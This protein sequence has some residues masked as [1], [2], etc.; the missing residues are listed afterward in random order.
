MVI[1]NRAWIGWSPSM[2]GVF[3]GPIH[4]AFSLS[5][6]CDSRI[7][8]HYFHPFSQWTTV[9]IRTNASGLCHFIVNIWCFWAL[10]ETTGGVSFFFPPGEQFSLEPQFDRDDAIS[11]ASLSLYIIFISEAHCFDDKENPHWYLSHLAFFIAVSFHIKSLLSKIELQSPGEQML[12]WRHVITVPYQ[13][14]T[15]ACVPRPVTTL[16]LS[17]PGPFGS[18]ML[19]HHGIVD[20]NSEKLEVSRDEAPLKYLSLSIC[21]KPFYSSIIQIDHIHCKSM[22]KEGLNPVISTAGWFGLQPQ[23]SLVPEGR[24]IT[25]V[26]E[27]DFPKLPEPLFYVMRG[28]VLSARAVRNKGNK[29]GSDIVWTWKCN[30]NQT[31]KSFMSHGRCCGASGLRYWAK[32]FK[33]VMSG[34]G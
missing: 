25:N 1:R 18:T 20:T 27:M 11:N 9:I 22:T 26:R 33:I 31:G 4:P 7:T 12:K 24:V 30:L 17:L 3:C 2:L 32:I 6:L 34:C 29:E 5:R 14:L 13:W 19:H 21:H 8:S 23:S 10:A 28:D 16:S 15:E